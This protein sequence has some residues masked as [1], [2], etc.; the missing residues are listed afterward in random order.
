MKKLIALLLAWTMVLG[1]AVPVLAAEEVPASGALEDDLLLYGADPTPVP[2]GESTPAPALDAGA[3]PE[4]EASPVPGTEQEPVQEPAEG[5][6]PE[7][8][9]EQPEELVTLISAVPE[10]V[11]QVDVSVR[12]ALDLG[13]N[14]PVFEATLRGAAV[15]TISDLTADGMTYSFQDV[16]AGEYTLTLTAPGFAGYTQSLA[17]GEKDGVRLALTVGRLAGYEAGPHPGVIIPGDVDGSGTVDWADADVLMQAVADGTTVGYSDLNGDGVTDL[18]DGELMARCLQLAALDGTVRT[19]SEERFV[20]ASAMR[21]DA[22]AGVQADGLAALF[23]DNDEKFTLTRNENI[24]PETPV[25][26]SFTLDG[27]QTDAILLNETNIDSGVIEI[28][29]ADGTFGTGTIG[30]ATEPV[31]AAEGPEAGESTPAPEVP[32][33]ETEPVAA[34]DAEPTAEPDFVPEPVQT[35]SPL[36]ASDTD[37]YAEPVAAA[38]TAEQPV[39]Q[40]AA[41][42]EDGA[43]YEV[44]EAP[45]VPMAGAPGGVTVTQDAGGNIVV[46]L[47]GRKAVKRVTLRITGTSDQGS[48]ASI[49]QVEFVNGMQERIPE[50]KMDVPQ[51][52]TAVPASRQFTV[53]WQPCVNVTGYEVEVTADGATEVF[54]LTGTSLTVTNFNKDDVRNYTAYTV[55]VQS[56][57]GDW[58]SGWSGAV[59]VT[60]VP[61]SAPDKPDNVKAEGGYQTVAVSW[62]NMKDTASYDLYYKEQSAESYTCIPDIKASSYTITELDSSKPT[63]YEVYVVGKNEFGASPESMHAS[64]TTT[65]PDPAEMPRYRLINRDAA[66][67]PGRSHIV[68]AV[69]NGATMVNSPLD[70]GAGTAWGTVDGNNASYYDR[71]CWDDGA[72][73]WVPGQNVGLSYTFDQA[74][75]MDTIGLVSTDKNM[76][77][78]YARIRWMDEQGAW[79]LTDKGQ[80][81][82]ER[83]TD[84]QGRTYFFL[85]LPEA[86]TTSQIQLGTA[87]YWAGNN[88]VC[89]TEVYFYAYDSLKN[90]IFGLYADDLHTTL[91]DDVTADELAALR[92]RIDATDEFGNPHPDKA[93]LL[94]ELETAEKIFKDQF[95]GK[96]V[97]VHTGITGS[98][99]EHGFTGLNAW[100]PLGV[101]AAAGE[102]LT[103]YVGGGSAKTGSNTNLELVMT[104]YHAESSA[105]SKVLTKLKVGANEVQIPKIWTNTGIESGGALYVQYN[106]GASGAD[107]Y[108][109]RVSGGTAVPVLDLYHVT[110]GGE[111]ASRTAAYV[112]ELSAYAAD[113]P[114]R[115]S[116]IHQGEGSVSS[117]VDYDYDAQNCILG[118]TDILLDT[119]MLSLP[120]QQVVAGCGGD[121]GK[122][123]AS[124]DA[125]EQMMHLFYQHKGLNASAPAAIDRIPNRHL[126]IRYQR[127]FSGAFM[128]ASGNHI[129]IGWNETAGMA[130]C[131]GV[132]ATGE[133]LY[134]SGNYFGWGIA[135]EIGH[136]I[137]QGCYAIAEI[138]NNYFAVLAQ[139]RESNDSVRFDYN[140]VYAKVTSGAK[141]S[142]A[143]VFTQLG[144]YWQLHLAYDKGYNF[145]TYDDYE[146]QLQNLFFA[147]VDTYARTPARAPAPGGVALTLQGADVDQTLMRLACAAAE[148]DLLDFFQRWGKTPDAA[149][150]AY[151]SQFEK[152]TRAIYYVCDNSRLYTIQQGGESKLRADGSTDAIGAVT[153]STDA[154]QANKVNIHIVSSGALEEGEVL[155]YEIVRCTVAGGQVEKRP[156]GFTT[157]RFFSDV[158]YAMNNRAVYYEVTLVDQYLNRSAPEVTDTVKI[159]HE[160]QLDKSGW[161]VTTAGLKAEPIEVTVGN[162]DPDAP[163]LDPSVSDA[164]QYIADGKTETV[165]E[166]TVTGAASVTLDFHDTQVITGFMVTA[167][168][169]SIGG[170][171]VD[172]RQ[173]GEWL[174]VGEGTLEG[175]E[176]VYFSNADGKYVSTYAADAMRL[177]LTAPAGGTV[178]IAELDALGLA[179]DN[180]DMG[181]SDGAPSI[182]YLQSAYVYG[183]EPQDIIPAGSLVFTGSYEGNA[184]YNVVM[185]YDQDGNAVA[186]VDGNGDKVAHQVILSHVPEN[187]PI[188]DTRDGIWVYWIEPQDMREGFVMP[189]MVRAELYRVNNAETNEGERLVSDSLFAAVPDAP[190]DITIDAGE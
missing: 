139:A 94:T 147:R 24:T 98:G 70:T 75:T 30:S 161:T 109:V 146:T 155:G 37:L 76:D 35:E 144:M 42:F 159:S 64:A 174:Q 17:V 102:K 20:P 66:G 58:T 135:H 6:G 96:A 100:Q 131:G 14:V 160:G 167:G 39:G 41:A 49:T 80:V 99:D 45:E 16:A 1:L 150:V 138:T 15:Y 183:E 79:H 78:T 63:T 182:G 11:G 97:T 88:F 53:R 65:T 187:G 169:A 157:E 67:N 173:N 179:G 128:Y 38:D 52:V 180:V 114:A 103:V 164:A 9:A 4:G 61:N 130:G 92:A 140:N 153:V 19:A 107:N 136:D 3:V 152:E 148:R 36:D 116:E 85:R 175:T 46:D 108:A 5:P 23:Q 122:L 68:A 86:V 22:S 165:Y 40:D 47:G 60:P 8:E 141:G 115:H 117:E 158:V 111:R 186:G 112:A 62:K 71:R 28:E 57:N 105:M 69:Q 56:V 12:K 154:D 89:V 119:M 43:E 178:S 142:S 188:Q 123:L 21:V 95:L 120:A 106:G 82:S 2:E 133:G 132:Q 48:L 31:T 72:G 168:G 54:P 51:G 87:R 127:M 137:N 104:Q 10:S 172:V 81:T 77:Y 121:A 93:W 190:G 118:A 171:T 110:D 84:S 151:A 27:A 34:A 59:T 55:R 74:Y 44:F 134:Q 125:M 124:L 184:A 90:D 185:L 149:T 176:T 170:Y 113:I 181:A 189:K 13:Y 33:D 29:Y 143:N 166:A 50:P 101:V 145:K 156:V 91:R 32:A 129:G 73:N 162:D 18:A 83:R 7:P 25:D 126:N 163:S 26:V 177:N